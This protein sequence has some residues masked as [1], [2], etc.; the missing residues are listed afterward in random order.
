MSAPPPNELPARPPERP[1]AQIFQDLGVP[2]SVL[3]YR[4]RLPSRNWLVFLSITGSLLGT[5]IYD[6]RECRK[7]RDSYKER[8]A[9]LALEPLA[10]YDMPRKVAVYACKPPGDEEHDR[11]MKYF[12]KYVKVTRLSPHS[13][14][15]AANAC[16]RSLYW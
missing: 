14:P 1:V 13:S 3:N 12:K 15:S 9:H 8:V 5:Y 6:R 4:L 16:T 10:S 7:I 11:S 2:K